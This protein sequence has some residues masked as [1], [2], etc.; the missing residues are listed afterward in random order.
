MDIKGG[1]SQEVIDEKRRNAK[2]LAKYKSVYNQIAYVVYNFPTI[3]ENHDWHH[4][5]IYYGKNKVNKVMYDNINVDWMSDEDYE[6]VINAFNYYFEMMDYLA[7]IQP[8]VRRGQ[9]NLVTKIGFM[10]YVVCDRLRAKYI[11]RNECVVKLTP[12]KMAKRIDIRL[13]KL[14][15]LVPALTGMTETVS[16]GIS[17]E[18]D[19]ILLK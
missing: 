15:D 11:P 9:S 3:T 13:K 2:W 5:K 7:E 6:K 19:T 1:D 10:M 18:V 12:E 8:M 17:A 4:A 16:M 14:E